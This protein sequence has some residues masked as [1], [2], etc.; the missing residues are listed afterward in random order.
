MPLSTDEDIARVLRET[1]NIALVG[2]SARPERPSH[3]VLK[4]LLDRGYEVYPVNP[5]LAEQQL[6]GRTVYARLADIPAEID[7]VDVFRQP[8][9]LPDIVQEAIQARARTIWTQLGVVDADAAAMAEQAGIEVVM[10]RCPA[11]ELPRL[12]ACSPSRD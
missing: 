4:F 3:R 10:D 5:G 9:F 6:L 2:A 11:I 1:Q 7:M 8:A 12:Q